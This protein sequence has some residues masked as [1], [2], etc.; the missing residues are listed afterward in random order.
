MKKLQVRIDD[1]THAA[2]V[3]AAKQ[4][5]RSLNSWIVLAIRGQVLR[6]AIRPEGKPIAEAMMGA[7]KKERKK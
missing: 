4:Q 3:E 7:E 6:E 1:T 2:A 5:I